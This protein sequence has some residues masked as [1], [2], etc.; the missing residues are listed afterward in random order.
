MELT[1]PE[2]DLNSSA[3]PPTTTELMNIPPEIRLQIYAALF[4]EIKIKHQGPT[5]RYQSSGHLEAVMRSRTFEPRRPLAILQVCKTVNQE[6]GPVSD[7][8]PIA[9]EVMDLPMDSDL[10]V[11]LPAAL[12]PRL[13]SFVTNQAGMTMARNLLMRKCLDPD[14]YER[15]RYVETK[16]SLDHLLVGV[17]AIQAVT[18]SDGGKKLSNQVYGN[19]QENMGVDPDGLSSRIAPL[20][21]SGRLKVKASFG[22]FSIEFENVHTPTIRTRNVTAVSSTS[23]QTAFAPDK[24]S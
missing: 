14:R 22:F 1:R 11:F 24:S 7:A 3:K 18:T 12:R 23:E 9:V 13:R 15:L 20:V 21:A 6:A 19:I 2:G 4:K 16:G 5:F 8:C 10:D 17:E